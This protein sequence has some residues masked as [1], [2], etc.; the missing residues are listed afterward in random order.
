M[1]YDGA[2]G[3]A[4]FADGGGRVLGHLNPGT[5]RPIDIEAVRNIQH[6]SNRKP[7]YG[8]HPVGG[9]IDRALAEY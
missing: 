7:P 1:I 5:S 9:V 4:C 2:A 8:V 6:D 3:G